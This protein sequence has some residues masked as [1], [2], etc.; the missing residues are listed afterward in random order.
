MTNYTH[1]TA[2]KA[3]YLPAIPPGAA[4]YPV[5][6]D[7]GKRQ[8]PAG[9]TKGDT[10]FLGGESCLFTHGGALMSA[11]L[12]L[13]QSSDRIP[14]PMITDRRHRLLNTTILWDSG[15]FQLIR[16]KIRWRGDHT[17]ERILRACEHFADVAV[18]LDCPPVPMDR[19]NKCGLM[20]QTLSKQFPTYQI[21]RDTTVENNR[22]Y[23]K[24]RRYGPK[25]WFLNVLQGNN[26]EQ[27]QDWYQH[28]NIF[29][30]DGWAFGGTFYNDLKELLRRI[31]IIRDDLHLDKTKWL[32]VLGTNRLAMACALTSIQ[33]ILSRE[34]G[35]SI[36]VS[37]D[38]SSPFTMAYG[39]GLAHTGY[40]IDK[41]GMTM[42]Q[43]R[44]P[45]DDY[46]AA[47]DQIDFPTCIQTAL[48]RRLKLSDICL[49][50][51]SIFA[52]SSWDILSYHLLANHNLE[53]LLNAIIGAHRVYLL[54]DR[55]ASGLCPD[56]LIRTRIGIEEVLTSE[57]PMD[58][59]SKYAHD[60][61]KVY[62][63]GRAM[64]AATTEGYCY[65]EANRG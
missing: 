24:H 57:R 48:S 46:S 13:G 37:Y 9:L 33:T 2:N 59:I 62:Q 52:P 22:Y 10:N 60:F 64:D 45:N 53:M 19:K 54:D 63:G 5:S 44:F 25:P 50:H 27:C 56:W 28:V 55:N 43:R 18:S 16:D 61:D 8:P 41:S 36:Q 17:R 6:P 47:W 4:E 35:R 58:A 15:G 1:L 3:I 12:A 39:Y 49:P 31:I 38:S 29:E 14:Q 20:Q 23:E 51:K 32:H 11:G 26:F 30:M 40:V 42:K 65:E 7:D 34:L 21:C